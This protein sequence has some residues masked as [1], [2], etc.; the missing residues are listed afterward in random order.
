MPNGGG[1]GNK[2]DNLGTDLDDLITPTQVGFYRSGKFHE[3]K[4]AVPP[5]DG[6]DTIDALAGNDTVSSGAGNDSVLGGAGN[7]S[8]G[9]S[10][11]NNTFFGGDG[12]DTIWSYGGNH[13]IYG[14]A[15]DDNIVA[16]GDSTIDGGVG[17]D[18]IW[19]GSGNQS[20]IG[21]SGNDLLIDGEGT[22]TLFGGDGDDFFTYRNVVVGG[23]VYDGGSG[24]D[25]LFLPGGPQYAYQLKTGVVEIYPG[26]VIGLTHP[27]TIQTT[28]IEYISGGLL[29]SGE[30]ADIDAT[31]PDGGG[32]SATVGGG[33]GADNP[34]VIYDMVGGHHVL[35]SIYDD[36]LVG[37][38][39]STLNGGAGNDSLIGG[40]G[41]DSIVGGSGTDT[42][43]AGA[44]DDVVVY[45][46]SAS[47]EEFLDGGTGDDTLVFGMTSNEF[48]YYKIVGDRVSQYELMPTVTGTTGDLYQSGDPLGGFD[49]VDF[50]HFEGGSGIDVIED[51]NPGR[52]YAGGGGNDQ[53]GGFGSATVDGGAGDDIVIAQQPSGVAQLTG[54]TGIDLFW[55][56]ENAGT[57][58]MDG[59][60]QVIITDMETQDIAVFGY[61]YGQILLEVSDNGTDVNI[62]IDVYQTA[63]TTALPWV[64]I[65]LQGIGDGTISS[66]QDLGDAGY[67]FEPV[68]SI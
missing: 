21:G 45:D 30:P 37:L 46:F 66:L 23:N 6:D 9:G 10:G 22:D 52:S 51:N 19:I 50:E 7:D 13:L 28:G 25:V 12:D 3:V 16:D 26:S 44:G 27:D 61:N 35:G 31:R 20:V 59:A 65:T 15:G 48:V 5:G 67:E 43:S 40:D 2:Q 64:T 39:G 53:I 33:T 4:N 60:A 34:V 62:A 63:T 1:K 17:D 56:L 55:I 8:I 47:S 68:F 41:D 32:G 38:G 14:G 36:T 54:G 57:A 11:G 58:P 18:T 24:E 49:V 29:P 42:I